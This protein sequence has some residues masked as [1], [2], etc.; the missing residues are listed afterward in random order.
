MARFALALALVAL[1]LVATGASAR[2]G[3]TR[4]RRIAAGEINLRPPLGM[5]SRSLDLPWAGRL[6]R[7]MRLK[8]SRYVRH[9]GEYK[10][11][12][13]FYGTWELVQ[14]LERAARRVAVRI[15]GARLS[16]GELSRGQGGAIAGHRSHES[17]R[18]VDI[19]FYMTLDSGA[20]YHSYAF[21][22]IN[23]NGRGRPPN[24]FLRFDD[25]RNWELVAKLVADGDARVQHI[26][27][28]RPIRRR[29]LMEGTRR[30]ASRAVLDRAK[31]VLSQPGHPHANHFHVRIYCAPAD[32][33][34]CQDRGPIHP[35]YPGRPPAG[36]IAA[37]T[38][39]LAAV[40]P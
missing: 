17:G 9:V 27:V 18:D 1:T 7:G 21:A 19:G 38:R 26:F 16:V 10:G 31:T 13:H 24:Q 3:G 30:R 36:Q 15:P 34:R 35:W 14:L 12:G 22:N 40:A 11:K 23:A 29:L 20:P 8:E 32:R 28:S 25:A 5:R 4:T 37:I 2:Q 33:P 39:P 6:K